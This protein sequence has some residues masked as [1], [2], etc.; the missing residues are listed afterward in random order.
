LKIE[1]GELSVKKVEIYDVT[2]KTVLTSH[3][4]TIDISHLQ[5][6]IYFIKLKTDKG[7]LTKKVIKQ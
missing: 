5:A 2:G 6:G 1:S 7:E 4:T 3:V